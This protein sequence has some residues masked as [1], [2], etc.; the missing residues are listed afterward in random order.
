MFWDLAAGNAATNNAATSGR[1]LMD[2]GSVEDDGVLNTKP[3][4]AQELY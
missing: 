1:D 3:R 2:A 4:A